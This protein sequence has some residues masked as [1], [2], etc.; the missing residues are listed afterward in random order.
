LIVEFRTG[1]SLFLCSFSAKA[2]NQTLAFLCKQGA[3]LRRA[4]VREEYRIFCLVLRWVFNNQDLTPL[5]GRSTI[6]T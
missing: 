4:Y 3:W 2:N 6:K 1:S 5:D